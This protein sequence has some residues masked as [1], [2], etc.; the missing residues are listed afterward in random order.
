MHKHENFKHISIH[1]FLKHFHLQ[2]STLCR[3]LFPFF[4]FTFKILYLPKCCWAVSTPWSIF[5]KHS[6]LFCLFNSIVRATVISWR[7]VMHLCVSWISHT[8]TYT[9]LLSKAIYFSYMMRGKQRK[10]VASRYRTRNLRVTRQIRYLLNYPAGPNHS[11]KTV[12]FFFSS[13]IL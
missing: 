11:Q 9:I 6:I 5:T 13:K 10:F 3:Q 4:F 8:I 2:T 7:S 12:F 1:L